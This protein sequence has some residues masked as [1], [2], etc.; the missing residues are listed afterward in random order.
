MSTERQ[1]DKLDA[2]R[3]AKIMLARHTTLIK[4]L[5]HRRKRFDKN[6]GSDQ[7]IESCFQPPTKCSPCVLPNSLQIHSANVRLATLDLSE[8]CAIDAWSASTHDKQGSETQKR[9]RDRQN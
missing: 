6:E 3:G 5:S 7:D 4:L 9:D 1:K 8:S 2:V